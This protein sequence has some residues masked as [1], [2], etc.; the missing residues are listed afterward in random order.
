MK[1]AHIFIGLLAVTILAV[2]ISCG[3]ARKSEPIAKPLAITN[4]EVLQGEKVFMFN[5]NQCHPRGEAGLAPAL[6][7][8]FLPG[9]LIRFVVR[10][11][12]G[13]MPKFTKSEISDEDIDNM[14][15]YLK[16]LKKND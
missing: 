10:T 11:G 1:K 15:A 2:I 14:I 13:P 7:N 8:K 6:N 9:F 4:R 16:V 5:C 12:P 3:S